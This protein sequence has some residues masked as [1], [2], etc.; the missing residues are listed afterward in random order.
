MYLDSTTSEIL[1]VKLLTV[2]NGIDKSP[3]FRVHKSII[4]KFKGTLKK[5]ELKNAPF[6]NKGLKY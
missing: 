3:P 4:D 6:R 1:A 2:I 5:I